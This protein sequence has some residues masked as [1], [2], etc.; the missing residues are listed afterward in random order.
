M[1]KKKFHKVIAFIVLMIVIIGSA[2]LG[3][4]I[5]ALNFHIQETLPKLKTTRPAKTTMAATT[6]VPPVSNVTLHTLTFEVHIDDTGKVTQED[7]SENYSQ[8]DEETMTV[9]TIIESLEETQ[10]ESAKVLGMNQ[11]AVSRL[12]KK[13]L[14][15]LRQQF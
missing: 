6:L 5:N 14:L 12:E 15:F 7:S 11:V 9:E 4:G 8:N 10:T 13:I 2:L 3:I 1:E